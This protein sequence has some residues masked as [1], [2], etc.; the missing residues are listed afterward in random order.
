[1]LSDSEL[2]RA[3]TSNEK[4]NELKRV[5]SD[6]IKYRKRIDSSVQEQRKFREILENLQSKVQKYRQKAAEA[7]VEA[8]NNSARGL[9]HGQSFPSLLHGNDSIGGNDNLWNQ[10]PSTSGD[11][12]FSQSTPGLLHA[13]ANYRAAGSNPILSSTRS[14]NNQRRIQFAESSDNFNPE[15]DPTVNLYQQRLKE[16]QY[17]N[18]ILEEMIDT[19]KRQ[20]ESTSHTNESLTNDLLTLHETLTRAEQSR[21]R[22][23]EVFKQREQKLKR[24]KQLLQ[25]QYYDVSMEIGTLR[26]K[27]NEL[28]SETESDLQNYKA[29]F[30]RCT[31]TMENRL[32]HH[33][34]LRTT[35][36]QRT[37]KEHDN[38]FEE[39]MKRYDDAVNKSL[40][41]EHERNEVSRKVI[42]LESAL[43]RAQEEKEQIE[44]SLK[45]IHQLP[46]VAEALGRRTRSVS[47]GKQ[48]M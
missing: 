41:N 17:R 32:K 23:S 46:E 31:K 35:T 3:T 37:A 16:E 28:K 21:L 39:V 22:S 15:S 27:I 25:R 26:R 13:Q 42:F 24:E 44:D 2:D 20:G 43:K 47:P 30:D 40:Q 19:L 8:I 1:M 5:P 6:L 11:Y 7:E 10:N 18:T 34:T 33:E 12:G 38:A 48:I 36:F 9:G 14:P 45:K 29:D 4:A